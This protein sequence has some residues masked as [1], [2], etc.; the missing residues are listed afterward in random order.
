MLC[1]TAKSQTRHRFA[2]QLLIIQLLHEELEQV[3]FLRKAVLMVQML[4]VDSL[5]QLARSM[6][7]V[8]KK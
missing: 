3:I 1:E 8:P 6:Y 5:A 7:Q 4:E 2:V